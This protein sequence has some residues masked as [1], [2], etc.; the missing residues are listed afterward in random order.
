[1]AEGHVC[2]CGQ[3]DYDH[4]EQCYYGEDDGHSHYPSLCCPECPCLSF[5]EAHPE[6]VGTLIGSRL[7]T[8][9]KT[10][11]AKHQIWTMER[12]VQRYIDC[13]NMKGVGPT[14]RWQVF[15]ACTDWKTD[16]R[17]GAVVPK[18]LPELDTVK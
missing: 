15:A 1:M 17:T 10:I 6:E 14:G 3:M 2:I 18:P 9:V 13:M 12:M 7:P 5:E 8:R 11:L 4:R 16:I